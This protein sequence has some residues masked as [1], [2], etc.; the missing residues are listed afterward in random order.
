MQSKARVT[1]NIIENVGGDVEKAA[2]A[3]EHVI[4]VV[5]ELG[6]DVVPGFFHVCM[7]Y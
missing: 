7:T 6:N 4:D 3:E 5:R 1:L 2:V